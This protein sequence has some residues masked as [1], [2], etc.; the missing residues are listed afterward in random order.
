MQ[1]S[2]NDI[3]G[4]A[5]V[6]CDGRLN[7]VAASKLKTA[8]QDAVEGGLNRVV[9]DLN[10]VEFI[11]SSGLGALISGLKAARQARG[12]LHIAVSTSQVLTALSLTRLDRVLQPYPTVGE[13]TR[14]W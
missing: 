11:D 3:D 9:V 4:I 8:V 2:R 7:M 14:D 12:D 6:T 5:V 10:G 1:L 13:A